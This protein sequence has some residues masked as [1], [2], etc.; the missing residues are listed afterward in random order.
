M[1]LATIQAVSP[2]FTFIGTD[3]KPCAD[4]ASAV[5]LLEPARDLMWSKSFV[6][7][8]TRYTFAGAAKAAKKLVLATFKDWYVPSFDELIL[9]PDRTRFNPALDTE[10]FTDITGGFCWTSTPDA[11][12]RSGLAW[13]VY[14]DGGYSGRNGQNCKGLLLVCRSA[15]ASQ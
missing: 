8:G 5:A 9:L 15:S 11:S 1:S 13:G 4:A 7:N 3:G 10:F 2:R 12:A 6:N 14:L